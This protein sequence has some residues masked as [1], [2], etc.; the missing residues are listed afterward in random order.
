[1]ALSQGEIDLNV[2]Q[3]T[4]Y[5]ENFNANQD[6]H[7]TGITPIPTVPAGLFGGLQND[8]QKITKGSII[9]IPD[10]PSNT[11]R[12]LLL[13]EKAEWITLDE[14]VDPIKATAD[15]IKDNPYD[16]DIV[17]LNSAQIPRSLEDFDYAVIPGSI[18]YS[19]GHKAEDS[20]LSEDV[21][22]QYELVATV[23]EKN[24]DSDWAQAVIDAYHSDDFKEFLDQENTDGY[25][26][27]PA[28]L[29]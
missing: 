2:D 7:L 14:S 23:D 1:V 21:K 20:L 5:L 8:L 27:I 19:S 25:W 4:A 16:L 26:F 15:N 11:A 24:D 9:G 29:K 12:A 3:H 10:D 6:T 13:L 28:E 18:V 22:K 17:Q